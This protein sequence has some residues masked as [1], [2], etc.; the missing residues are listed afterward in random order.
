M[1]SAVWPGQMTPHEPIDLTGSRARPPHMWDRNFGIMA[2]P[3]HDLSRCEDACPLA[4]QRLRIRRFSRAPPAA[5]QRRGPRPQRTLALQP[6]YL[7]GRIGPRSGAHE[8]AEGRQ[9]V[10]DRA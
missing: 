8:A 2:L 7:R 10:R 6:D 4:Q 5:D 9:E 1:V 3:G